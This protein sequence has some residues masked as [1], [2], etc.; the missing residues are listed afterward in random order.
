MNV[1][2]VSPC[3]CVSVVKIVVGLDDKPDDVEDLWISN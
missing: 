2:G 3:L 1:F